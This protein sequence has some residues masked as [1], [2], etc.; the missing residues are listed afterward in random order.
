MVATFEVQDL[1][2]G[3]SKG[4]QLFRNADMIHRQLIDARIEKAESRRV[5]LIGLEQGNLVSI[6]AMEAVGQPQADF[7]Q[8]REELPRI[9]DGDR[10]EQ[11]GHDIEKGLADELGVMLGKIR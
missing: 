8:I 5:E 4:A 9:P 10:A 6:P 1:Y 11:E 3:S 7:Q 2:A